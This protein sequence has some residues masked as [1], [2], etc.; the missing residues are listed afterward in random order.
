MRDSLN[1]PKYN[2]ML[3]VFLF[4]SFFISPLSLPATT[5]DNETLFFESFK[6][7]IPKDKIKTVRDL[8]DK[9]EEILEGKSEAI[10][11]D[12]RTEVEFDSGHI[13]STNNIDASYVYTI[14]KRFPDPNVEIWAFC[15]TQHRGIYF[16]GALYKYGYKNVYLVENGIVGWIKSGYPLVNK[17]MGKFKVI[18]YH[19][20]F[21]EDYI[22]RDNKE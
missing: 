10:I 11:I 8:H 2:I 20:R 7:S 22:Y 15:R 12:I 4:L 17:Y 16:V 3:F 1:L 14:P 19:K 13:E 6:N 21:D 9:W 18:E 5:L